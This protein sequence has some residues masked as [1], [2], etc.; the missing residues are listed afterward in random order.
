MLRNWPVSWAVLIGFLHLV[1][2]R[3]EVYGC[4]LHEWNLGFLQ[5][6]YKSHWFS[7]HIRGL[8][9]LVSDPR[10][11]VPYMDPREDLQAHDI[12]FLFSVLS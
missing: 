6:S 3:K 12:P 1:S 9:F 5:L 4:P 2:S 10:A 11:G 7:N 8:V